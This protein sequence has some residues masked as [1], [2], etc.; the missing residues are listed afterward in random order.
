[1]SYNRQRRQIIAIIIVCVGKKQKQNENKEIKKRL[2][3]NTD[4]TYTFVSKTQRI[5]IKY[6]EEKAT[7]TEEDA[8]TTK[9]K[10]NIFDSE[11]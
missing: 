11:T 6:Q 3:Y 5:I 8:E 7:E 1:M 4:I 10:K 2:H 9:E